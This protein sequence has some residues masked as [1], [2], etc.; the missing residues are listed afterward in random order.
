MTLTCIHFGECGGCSMLDIP[1]QE[2]LRQKQTNIQ[3][4]LQDHLQAVKLQVSVP[5]RPPTHDRSRILYPVQPDAEKGLSMGIYR[6]QSHQVVAVT[7]CQIQ[8]PA[9]TTLGQRAQSIFRKLRLSPYDELTGQGLLRGFA[10][11]L[12]Y[13]SNE[14]LM[15][16]ITT[17]EAFAKA[18]KCAELLQSAAA[19]LVARRGRKVRVVGVVRNIND[20][21][22]NALLG[23]EQENLRGRGHLVD[24]VRGL[25]FQISFQSFYQVHRR[26]STL[27]YA[28]AMEMLGSVQ[29]KRVI[30][31]Y[32][33]IGTFG[34]RI[35]AA[36][37]KDVSIVE[38]NPTACADAQASIKL[39][40]LPQTR[41]MQGSFAEQDLPSCPDLLVVDPN[42]AGLQAAGQQQVIRLAAKQLLY[43][44]CS[45][46]SLAR[47]LAA[48]PNYQVQEA[49]MV[50]LF[51][52]TEHVEVLLLLKHR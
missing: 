20:S 14:L 50:D 1:I 47:D 28:P 12:A 10:A 35:A 23:R 24:K 44:S 31:A 40:K 3:N 22:G 8:H 26:A 37:A 27:L 19:D 7:Q 4:L 45:P 2:Q 5:D 43:V 49:R 21:P 16:V 6:R 11:R 38:A 42:R 52:Y 15:G 18:Q 9:L 51:P 30:D 29:G 41:V 34:L 25:Q 36:G 46:T 32:G 33:G 48:M 39:N 13:G 17:Q